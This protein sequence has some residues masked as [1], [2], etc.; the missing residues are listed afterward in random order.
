VG[1]VGTVANIVEVEIRDMNGNALPQG[2][3]GEICVCGPNITKGYLNNPEETE[4]AF[5]GDWYR[6]GDIGVF[7]EEGYLF[8]V[9][10]LKDM[11]ITGG[12]N[13]YSREVEEVLYTHPE[14]LECAVVGLPDA[15]YG[16][17]VTAYIIPRPG[18]HIDGA[19]LKAYMKKRLASYKVPKAFIEVDNLPKSSAGK[20]LKREIRNTYT[21]PAS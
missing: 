20:L 10:R 4:A 9:D 16:E 5:W 11:I 3:R 12:E 19:D 15:E 14:V 7:D 21:D 2:E 17:R 18:Q 13:V 8:I 1:S 6:T